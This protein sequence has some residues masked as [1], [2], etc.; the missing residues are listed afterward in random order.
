[1]FQPPRGCGSLWFE[2]MKLVSERQAIAILGR[3]RIA[4]RQARAVLHTG[5]AGE[6]LRTA[7]A[8]LYEPRRVETLLARPGVSGDA[9]RTACPRGVFLARRAVSVLE[10]VEAQLA[11]ASSGWDLSGWARLWFYRWF[12][13]LGPMPAVVTVG[14]FVLLGAELSGFRREPSG[15]GRDRF[16]LVLQPPGDWFQAF[17]GRRMRTWP[18]NPWQVEGCV[19]R[20]HPRRD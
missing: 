15:S 8:I 9:A 12:E 1:L 10:S 17:A 13:D 5:L 20:G 2:R 16:S 18:G 4:P 11:V 14:G 7:S 19:G 6:P 3:G